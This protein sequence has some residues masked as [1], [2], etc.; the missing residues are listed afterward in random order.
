MVTPRAI[1]PEFLFVIEKDT[2]YI[3]RS[4]VESESV[5]MNDVKGMIFEKAALYSRAKVDIITDTLENEETIKTIDEIKRFLLS[6]V[7]SYPEYYIL[8]RVLVPEKY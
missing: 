7:N 8:F 5:Q 6:L 2:V 4:S 1:Y 3:P